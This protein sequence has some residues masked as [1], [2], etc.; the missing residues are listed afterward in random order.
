M[1]LVLTQSVLYNMNSDTD[2]HRRHLSVWPLE[3]CELLT[4]LEI[5]LTDGQV[6]K[7][8]AASLTFKIIVFLFI[9]ISA[10]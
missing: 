6:V 2:E 3:P 9:L 5:F 1:I 7:Q 8:M 4:G 10:S